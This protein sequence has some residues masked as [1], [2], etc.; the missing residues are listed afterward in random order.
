MASYQ[1]LQRLAQQEQEQE[2]V[3][4]SLPPTKQT[5]DQLLKY[6]AEFLRLQEGGK[7][8]T[9]VE[10]QVKSTL[11]FVQQRAL[12]SFKARAPIIIQEARAISVVDEQSLQAAVVLQQDIKAA[13]DLLEAFKRPEINRHHKAHRE[14]LAELQTL[15]APWNTALQIL[16]SASAAYQLKLRREREEAARRVQE[17][18]QRVRDVELARQLEQATQAEQQERVE[19]ILE[20][21]ATPIPEIPVVH[22][23]VRVE[24]SITRTKHGYTLLDPK[25]LNLSW[26]LEC[27]LAEIST[28]GE[29]EWL[30]RQI[31]RE[32][33]EKG[34]RA[35]EVVGRGAIE[36]EEGVSAGVRR[37]R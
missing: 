2:P 34:K 12:D 33:K 28:K 17:E 15:T 32:V 11:T 7:L 23:P 29:C 25:K 26:V 6:Q 9:E 31:K 18:M 16:S 35:E 36:Y 1:D 27:I 21:A 5:A 4:E 20:R 13:I 24:G 3:V 19:E 22:V 14:A 8:S 10:E 30:N 37:R